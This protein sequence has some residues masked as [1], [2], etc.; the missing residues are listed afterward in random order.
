MFL[1]ITLSSIGLPG[2]NGFIGE[3]LILIGTWTSPIAGA[4]W[5]SAIAGTGVV[6]GAVY[7]L[8][9]YQKTMFGP[10]TN[11]ANKSLPDLSLREW[12]TFAPLLVA[13]VVIGVQPQPLLSVVK[14]PVDE[15]IARVTQGQAGAAKTAQAPTTPLRQRPLRPVLREPTDADEGLPGGEP[16]RPP[17]LYV[18]NRAP[19][20]QPAK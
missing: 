20:A 2:T 4:Q 6:L 13:I 3:F 12:L 18:P 10:V 5:L 15:F 1:V 7:M 9:M 11:P 16:A 17:Q 14:Q 19:L 8:W